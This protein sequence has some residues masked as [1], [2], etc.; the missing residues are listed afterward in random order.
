MRKAAIITWCNNHGPANYGQV[1]QCY[2]M[3]RIVAGYGYQ[4]ILVRYRKKDA[5]DDK[6]PSYL[7]GLPASLYETIYEHKIEKDCFQVRKWKFQAFLYQKMPHTKPCYSLQEVEKATKDCD[8]LICGS[9]QIW[10]TVAYDPVYFLDFGTDKQK[11]IAFAPSL[12]IDHADIGQTEIFKKVAGHL[13]RFDKISVREMSSI[14]ILNKYTDKKIH[15]ILDP[16]LHLSA[17]EWDKIISKKYKFSSYIF[18]YFL[19]DISQYKRIIRELKEKFHLKNIV[20][21][22]TNFSPSGIEDFGEV[23]YNAGPKDFISLIKYADVVC[24]DSF[25]GVAFSIIY[26]KEFYVVNRRQEKE[27]SS[28]S[29]IRDLLECK[30]MEERFI[31]GRRLD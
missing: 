31:T 20:I 19:G 18:C 7:K 2:A 9:D 13:K 12:G 14:E 8:L 29:R 22:A 3:I 6:M 26:N 5:L 1:L 4:P 24:T 10:N 30:G 15:H 27:Y 11:R 25:H 17:E 16:T 28:F 23:L 21:L